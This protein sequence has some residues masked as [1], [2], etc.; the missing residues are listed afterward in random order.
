MAALRID[1]V[2]IIYMNEIMTS[3]N[4]VLGYSYDTKYSSFMQ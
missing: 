3:L 1:F 2:L 4:K